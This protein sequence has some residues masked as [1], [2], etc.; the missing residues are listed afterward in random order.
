[1]ASPKK[2]TTTLR[3]YSGTATSR[4]RGGTTANVD[5]MCGGTTFETINAS[6][7]FRVLEDSTPRITEAGELRILE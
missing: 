5:P 3:D 4:Q 2:S 6:N 1:M 7:N